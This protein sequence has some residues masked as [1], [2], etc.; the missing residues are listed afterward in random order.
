MSDGQTLVRRVVQESD[1]AQ[2]LKRALAERHV[3]PVR[4]ILTRVA[5]DEAFVVLDQLSVGEQADLVDL[6]GPDELLSL[7]PRSTPDT[8]NTDDMVVLGVARAAAF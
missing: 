7:L 1:A 2:A 8:R 4:A 5:S 6:L 3:E